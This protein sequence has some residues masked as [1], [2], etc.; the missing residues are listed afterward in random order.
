MLWEFGFR[1]YYG[2]REGMTLSFALDA[3]CPPQIAKGRNFAT[4]MCVKGANASGKT[5]VLRGISFLAKFACQSFLSEPDGPIGVSTHFSSQEPVELFAEF[6]VA[7][8]K[9]F[10]ELVVTHTEVVREAL[11]RTRSKRTLVIERKGNSFTQLISEFSALGA[12]RLRGNVS[13]IST[14]RQYGLYELN[15]VI[16]FFANI[17]GNVSFSGHVYDGNS[18]NMVAEELFRSPDKKEFV[19]DFIK[20][21]D[22]GLTNLVIHEMEDKDP[23]DPSKAKKRYVPIFE[24]GGW[25]RGITWYTESN[26]TRALVSRLPRIKQALASGGVLLA[27]E[28]DLHLHPQIVPKLVAL[29]DDLETNPLGAQLLFSTHDDDVLDLAGKYRTVLV[30][31]DDNESFA[32]RL[33]EIAGDLVRNDRPV[34]TI[35]KAGKIGGTPRL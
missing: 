3:N 11:S 10:Y 9:Y 24:H 8:I 29:F 30:N 22:V 17:T 18:L 34:S 15:D 25:E 14:A 20:S 5:T 1:N 28:L 27:D 13:F 23:L 31:K 16:G 12:M 19:V 33:D 7:G 26:G 6:E 2:F 4:L 32:Y 21:I 35:Y